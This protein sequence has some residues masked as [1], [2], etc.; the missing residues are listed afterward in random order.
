M[1]GASMIKRK[2]PKFYVGKEIEIMGKT[3]KIERIV[4]RETG[5]YWI[6]FVDDKVRYFFTSKGELV[7]W[8]GRNFH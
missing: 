2:R 1:T 6:D 4:P 3:R 7:S 5:G 8:C